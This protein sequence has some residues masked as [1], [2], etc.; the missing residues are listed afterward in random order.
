MS[1]TADSVP[2]VS[3]ID[4]IPAV[5]PFAVRARLLTP[6][7][8][9]GAAWEPD[10]LLVVDAAG[11][12]AYAG[13]AAGHPAAPGAVDLRPLLALPG[14]V[15]LHVHLPQLPNAGRGAGLDVLTW[16]ERYIFPLERGWADDGQG[17]RSA[18]LA[19]RALASAG[20]TTALAYCAAYPGSTD[21]AFAAAEDH[22][23]RAVLGMV[24]MDR[25]SYVAEGHP[26]RS[27]DGAIA[28]SVALCERWHGADGG[29]LGYAFTP[30]FAL[31]CTREMLRE[32]AAAARAHDAYWQTH[33]SED[34]GEVAEV[35]RAFPEAHDYVD[36]YEVAGGLGPRS[37]MAHAIHL[38]DHGLARLV[39]TGTRV[40]HCPSSNLFLSS[41]LMP[42]A[43]YLDAGLTIGLGS[44]VAGGPR[45]SLFDTM[46]MGFSAQAARLAV[47][48]D[49]HTP[50]DPL[51]WLRL[52]TLD[53]ARALGL[54]AVTGSLE[55]GKEADLILVDVD[56]TALPGGPWT[57]DDDADPA[58]LMSRLIFREHPEM[59]RAAF[60]RGRR[61][62]G[63]AGWERPA[64]WEGAAGVEGPEA[65]EEPARREPRSI[66]G[67][68]ADWSP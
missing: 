44:D 29:R 15:D 4:P 28:A 13:P 62:P 24:L 25:G 64:G 5:P 33:L 37:V 63:P 51:A 27:L 1:V 2:N 45:L 66:Q 61:L 21:V 67:A 41:G 34:L 19:F 49:D 50:L 12:L 54:D 53:G 14:L 26:A 22:G 58:D 17:A 32:S 8:A 55:P 9:G 43:R 46:K 65:F 68:A 57:A 36:V 40:A 52:G 59:V 23:I 35:A 16:L 42:L 31:S 7:A 38:T 6:L 56:R 3:P 60:V 47:G 11:R 30:R 48:D 39:E 10:G 18:A 20:T